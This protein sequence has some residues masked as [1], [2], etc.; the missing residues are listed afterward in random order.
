MLLPI[1][2]TPANHATTLLSP[3]HAPPH[4]GRARGQPSRGGPAAQSASGSGP[5]ALTAYV[6]YEFETC[7][8]RR[9]FATPQQLGS[10]LRDTVL[11]QV[12]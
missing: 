4:A 2:H 10:S 5:P 7:D 12:G 11:R 1:Y 8:G 3:K 6:A 9:F